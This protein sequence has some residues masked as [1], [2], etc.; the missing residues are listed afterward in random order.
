MAFYLIP[1]TILMCFSICNGLI[2][3]CIFKDCDP[4]KSRLLKSLDQGVPYM[5]LLQFSSMP[6]MAGL[7]VAA[8]FSG[9]LR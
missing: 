9:T 8:V 7:F 6:G 5:A 4:I 1:S 3:Y 2:M